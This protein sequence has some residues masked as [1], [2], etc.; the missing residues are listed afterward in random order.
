MALEMKS[1]AISTVHVGTFLERELREP[2]IAGLSGK[3]DPVVHGVPEAT[4]LGGTA[5]GH[6]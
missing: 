5:I 6:S 3:P 1:S 2:E 4:G